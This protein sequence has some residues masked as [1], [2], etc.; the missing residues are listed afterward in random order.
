MFNNL[1]DLKDLIVYG[2]KSCEKLKY[3]LVY[4]NANLNKKSG[5]NR[6]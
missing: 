6:N 5:R 4:N 1:I 2:Q 3:C